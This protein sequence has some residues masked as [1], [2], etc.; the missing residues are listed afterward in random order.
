MPP[1]ALPEKPRGRLDGFAIALS[2]L[3][4]AHCLA[5]AILLAMFSSIAGPFMHESVHEIGLAVAVVLGAVALGRGR[6][7]HGRRL[8][9]WIG[10][11]GLVVMTIGIILPH[12]GG[13]IVATMIG[14]VLLA[15]GHFMN[16]RAARDR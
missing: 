2:A 1:A 3:C 4:L 8:P 15:S 13:E 14:V 11:A 9:L 10:S 5:S 16:Q 7:L 6:R 12:H